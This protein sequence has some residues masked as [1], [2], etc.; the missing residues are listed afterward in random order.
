MLCVKAEEH[1]DRLKSLQQCKHRMYSKSFAKQR[2][3]NAAEIKIF[4]QPLLTQTW[5]CLE[6]GIT[7]SQENKLLSNHKNNKDMIIIRCVLPKLD[8]G[9]V[10]ELY[11]D[12][13][14]SLL[15]FS[16]IRGLLM[17]LKCNRRAEQLM[18][19][20]R[21]DKL[22][23]LSIWSITLWLQEKKCNKY[24]HIYKQTVSIY[25]IYNDGVGT[26][27]RHGSRRTWGISLMK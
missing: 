14:K 18:K 15:I 10:S 26:R 6:G 7:F 17:F 22:Y 3:Q 19:K 5:L 21:K 16:A 11:W 23:I 2:R 25:I 4:T 13:M 20:P 12:L 1:M 9:S 8:K 24:L 27:R